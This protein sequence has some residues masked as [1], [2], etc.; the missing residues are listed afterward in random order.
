M[1]DRDQLGHKVQ[2]V[3]ISDVLT[4]GIM[5]TQTGFQFAG[6]L[7]RKLIQTNVIRDKIIPSCLVLRLFCSEE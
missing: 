2:V 1:K 4:V 3:N 5:P 7:F 6:Y